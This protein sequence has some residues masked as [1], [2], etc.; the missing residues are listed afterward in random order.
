MREGGS[1]RRRLGVEVG[2]EVVKRDPPLLLFDGSDDPADAG[3]EAT[4]RKGSRVSEESEG[5]KR[6]GE[7]RAR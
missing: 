7:E 4:E 1:A 2:V 3:P 5:R 6:G